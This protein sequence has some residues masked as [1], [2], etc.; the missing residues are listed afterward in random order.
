MS[1]HT[2]LIAVAILSA[3]VLGGVACAEESYLVSG[4]DQAVAGHVTGSFMVGTEVVGDMALDCHCHHVGDVGRGRGLFGR[5]GATQ[6][7]ER[8]YGYP[9]LF[10]NHYTQGHSNETN[11]QMLVAPVPTPPF[12]GHTFS[13]YQPLHPEELLYHHCNRYHSYYDGGRGMNHT[14]VRYYSP[15]L[16]QAVSNIYWNYVRLPR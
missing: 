13:T 12:V 2:Q 11:A 6:S 14:K 7:R 16:R 10:Y 5:R 1:G 9:D 8:E 15:P 4:D 3:A